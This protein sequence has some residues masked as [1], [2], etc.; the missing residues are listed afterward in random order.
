MGVVGFPKALGPAI[1][2]F[3]L[4]SPVALRSFAD[5]TIDH[6]FTISMV[7]MAVAV[8]VAPAATAPKMYWS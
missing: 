1:S 2:G 7:S 4:A 6:L 8:A 3:S 5:R